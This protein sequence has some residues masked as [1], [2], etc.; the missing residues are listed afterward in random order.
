MGARRREEGRLGRGDTNGI[1]KLKSELKG[2][3]GR[4][5]VDRRKTNCDRT[6]Y[7]AITRFAYYGGYLKGVLRYVI[8]RSLVSGPVDMSP[9]CV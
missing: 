6:A 5:A 2:E 9:R 1:E 7:R 8:W 4:F 3:F